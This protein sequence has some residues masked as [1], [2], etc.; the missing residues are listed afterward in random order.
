MVDRYK[1][2]GRMVAVVEAQ[3]ESPL[4]TVQ[5][6]PVPSVPPPARGWR[7]AST[8]KRDLR[9]DLL[10]GFAVFAMVADH[11]GG[12]SWLYLLSGGNRFFVSAAEG[13]VFISGVIVAVVYGERARR[14]GIR[15]ATVKLLNRAWTLYALAVW[16][17]L[18]TAFAATL[19]GLPRGVTLAQDPARFVLDVIALRRTFY[20]VDVMLFYALAMLAAPLALWALAR[21]RWWILALASVGLWGAYQL[22]PGVI[23]IPW[24]ITDNPVFNFAAWQILFFGGMLVGHARNVTGRLRPSRRAPSRWREAALPIL[25]VALCGLIYLHVTNAAILGPWAPDGDAAALL[26]RWFDKSALPFP[27]LVACAIVFAFLWTLVSRCWGPIRRAFGGFLLPLGQGALYAYAAHLFVIIGLQLLVLQVWQQGRATDYSTLDR[28]L[29]TLL[30]IAG[31]G[32]VWGLTRARFLLAVIVPLGAPP[33]RTF[34]SARLGR[35]LPRPADSLLAI[36]LVVALCV[37][38][39][40]PGR[41]GSGAAFRGAG[42]TAQNS[43]G[44]GSGA[45][46]AAQPA[47]SPSGAA[48]ASTVTVPRSVAGSA[49]GSSGYTGRSD[50][51]GAA[52]A[53]AAAAAPQGSAQP[54][55]TPV[56]P[57]AAAVSAPPPPVAS[58]GYLKDGAFFSDALGRTMPYG[59]YLPPTYDS[60]PTRRYPVVYMLHGAGG[61]YSEWVAYGLPESAEDLIWNGEVQPMIIVMPQGDQSYF[62]NHVGTDETRWGDYIAFDLVA[63]IDATY[64][65][66]PQP[67]SRAIGGLSMG[68]FGALQL[69]FTYPEIFGVVGAH[70]PAL[71]TIAQL[72]DIIDPANSN[73]GAEFDP[74]ELAKT[75]DPAYAPKV[76]VDAGAEDEWAERALL[77]G[78]ILDGRGIPHQVQLS[79]GEH[80]A[81]YWTGRAKDYVRFYARALVGGPVGVVAAP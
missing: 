74:L 11:I 2:W 38:F 10:R 18:T 71:R 69:A 79:P 17:A 43:G 56:S 1:Q 51:T 67:S 40:I 3:T 4:P 53:P 42:T 12:S 34:V 68:G 35:V 49:R 39:L 26:D 8:D 55:P 20:L 46:S 41:V 62:V 5:T 23:Q 57:I 21:G 54:T 78:R 59:T 60:D 73:A 63:Y 66:I 77:L 61:H 75:L 72:S 47:L 33:L 44:G 58:G 15:A 32:I 36:L 37:P 48:P 6:V 7:F 28:N 65:T 81:E 9:L 19:F 24:R 52:T 31:L 50:Q 14:E 76:W 30:Q 13:F 25:A 27:R 29:D 64:R 80:T 22:W 45:G 16:L 70:S